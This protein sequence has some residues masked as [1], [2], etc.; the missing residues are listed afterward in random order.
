MDNPHVDYV[1]YN[2]G[3][4][5]FDVHIMVEHWNDKYREIII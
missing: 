5:T 2:R 4:K 1:K 3:N